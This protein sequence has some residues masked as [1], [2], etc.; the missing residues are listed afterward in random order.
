MRFERESPALVRAAIHLGVQLPEMLLCSKN[1]EVRALAISTGMADETL[2]AYLTD[3]SPLAIVIAAT[4]RC[5][6]KRLLTLLS[7]HRWQVRSAAL[8]AL[9]RGPDRP[10]QEVRLLTKQDSVGVRA[11]AVELLLAWSDDEWLQANLIDGASCKSLAG[12]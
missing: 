10:L 1:V 2:E 4:D 7:D 3:E 9:G 11:T 5:G 6:T 12:D 8:T